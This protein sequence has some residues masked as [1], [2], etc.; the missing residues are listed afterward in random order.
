MK[1]MRIL[2]MAFLLAATLF[3]SACKGPAGDVGP[4]GAAGPAGPAGAA[5]PAGNANVLQINYA[6]RTVTGNFTLNMPGVD[7]NRL[8]NSLVYL[9]VKSSSN[10]Y[11]YLLP[12]FTAG[13]TFEY[14]TWM[15]P[16]A[17]SQITA[18]RVTGGTGNDVF[19][20]LKVLVIQNSSVVNGRRA[21]V[22]FSD[23]NAVKAYYNL[24]D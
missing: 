10:N 24:A 11:W 14:R 9:Y 12:G 18:S 21:A 19:T 23:Y 1:P 16:A 6:G 20:A 3:Q 2:T 7:A 5:G 8:D 22:D 15:I 13:G 17:T 4:A